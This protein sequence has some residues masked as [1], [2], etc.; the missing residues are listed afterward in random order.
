[1]LRSSL[2]ALVC[3]PLMLGGALLLDGC[4]DG[5]P[6]TAPP[7]DNAES[8]APEDGAADAS[9]FLASNL[10]GGKRYFVQVSDPHFGGGGDAGTFAGI[11]PGER[12]S[13]AIEAVAKL[14]PPPDFVVITGDLTDHGF[15]GEYDAFRQA[16]TA[17]T[18]L[19]FYVLR[20]NHDLSL[21]VFLDAFEDQEYID[22]QRMVTT[23]A[24]YALDYQGVRM[25]CLDSES[26]EPGGAE[27]EWLDGEVASVADRPLLVL[28]HRHI[29]PI[30]VPLVDESGS[31]EPQAHG[32][33]LEAQIT[34]APGLIAMLCG[35][36]HYT[37]V[38]ETEK[39]TQLSLTSSFF[40]VDDLSG[41]TKVRCVH[42][43]DGRLVWT[44]VL[45]VPGGDIAKEYSP[46]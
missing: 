45:T 18:D 35:H 5:R 21:A 6:S 36:I 23:G 25:L 3:L 10:T 27:S 19:P 44:A 7:A 41:G 39:L 32:D 12:F 31:G 1:M 24:C 30:G 22:R 37:Q 15:I 20:G 8:D 38:V 11:D 16:L 4:N 13:R 14:D 43:D 2:F 17:A 26:Y 40:A 42:V 33:E 46:E 28:T 34:K 29:H 9:A